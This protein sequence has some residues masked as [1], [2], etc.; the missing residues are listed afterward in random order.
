MVEAKKGGERKRV[1][2]P[3]PQE[4]E[5]NLKRANLPKEQSAKYHPFYQGKI[6][7]VPRVPVRSFNDFAIWYTPGVAQ[8]C[9]DIKADPQL[10][11]SLTNKGN[12]V[13]G[14]RDGTRV[15]DHGK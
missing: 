13:A 1:S 2:P 15:L 8:P 11:W 5:E 6:E 12:Q 4:V 10:V 14:T 9:L 3:T 7:V